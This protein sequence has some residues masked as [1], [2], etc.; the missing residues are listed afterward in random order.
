[1]NIL[2]DKECKKDLDMPEICDEGLDVRSMMETRSTL[3]GFKN[4]VHLNTRV[5]ES[6]M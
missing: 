4:I 3:S 2:N 1:M 5:F 6:Q